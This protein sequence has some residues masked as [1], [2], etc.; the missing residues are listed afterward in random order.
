MNDYIKQLEDQNEELQSRLSVAESKVVDRDM[1]W[2]VLYSVLHNASYDVNLSLV[3]KSVNIHYDEVNITD[4]D[5]G[6][7][8]LESLINVL[9]DITSK[10]KEILN[11]AEYFKITI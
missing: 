3:C 10:R 9:K 4:K 1:A 6:K 8:E 7:Q 5:I 2:K 11:V